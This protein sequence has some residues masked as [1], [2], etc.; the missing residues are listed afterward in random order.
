MCSEREVR[1]LAERLTLACCP[2]TVPGGSRLYLTMQGR[3]ALAPHTLAVVETPSSFSSKG[4]E[5]RVACWLP[6]V[7]EL[8]PAHLRWTSHWSVAHSAWYR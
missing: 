5:P 4:E 1:D 2:G 6:V 8:S 7:S 3:V